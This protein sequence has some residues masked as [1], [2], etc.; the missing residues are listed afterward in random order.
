MPFTRRFEG[1]SRADTLTVE[2]DPQPCTIEIG[3]VMGEAKLSDTTTRLVLRGGGWLDVTAT[4]A[5][6][7]AVVD[8]QPDEPIVP[9]PPPDGDITGGLMRASRGGYA[10]RMYGDNRLGDWALLQQNGPEIVVNYFWDPDG[11]AD[12]NNWQYARVVD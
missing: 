3:S 1:S 8:P 6:V 10:Y 4:L 2:D 7:L 12:F 11:T 5:E 9:I